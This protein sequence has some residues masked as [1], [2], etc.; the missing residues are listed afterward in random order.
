MGGEQ[1]RHPGIGTIEK[2][3]EE[4]RKFQG[5]KR[6]DNTTNLNVRVVRTQNLPYVRDF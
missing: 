6:L 2:G 3:E 1:K 4:S 5:I